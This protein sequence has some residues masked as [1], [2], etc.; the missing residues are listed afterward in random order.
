[1]PDNEFMFY[2]VKRTG[3]IAK[4]PNCAVLLEDEWDD[5]FQFS[6]MYSVFLFDEEGNQ[7]SLGSVKIGQVDMKQDQRR[8]D[9]PKSFTE[10]DERFFSLGQSEEYYEILGKLPPRLKR[11]IIDGLRD[12][13]ADLELWNRA[14]NKKVTDVSLTRSVSTRS[15]KGQFRRLLDG[16]A[17]L[18]PYNFTFTPP[19]R[20]NTANLV[21]RLEFHV[22][23]ESNPPTNV[24]V[25]IGRNGVGKTRMLHL[26]TKALVASKKSAAQSGKFI[27][28]DAFDESDSPFSGVVTVSFSAFDENELFPEQTN[29]N[30]SLRYYYIGL[31]R[32]S[33]EETSHGRP[34]SPKTL[35]KE[36]VASVALCL[37]GPRS[38]RWRRALEMLEADQIFKEAEVV[39][40]AKAPDKGFVNRK[41]EWLFKHLSSGHKIVLLTMTRLVEVVEEKTLVLIDEPEAHLH[42]PLLSAFVRSLSDLLINR[43]GVAIIATHSPVVLQEVPKTC[44]W[45]LRRSGPE[46]TAERPECETFGE[47]VG[48]LTREVFKLEVTQTGFHRLLTEAA[49]KG[50]SFDALSGQFKDELGAEA[51]AILRALIATR[52]DGGRE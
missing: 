26:M 48:V 40:L 23:P 28:K 8:P 20:P 42:P 15:I 16:G 39:R 52:Q 25:L 13:V 5:W 31:R 4:G 27:W 21:K 38:L 36:F 29:S 46:A 43:N 1:M 49:K 50:G 2:V 7:Q 12:V 3:S 44:V 11:K 33:G 24:H 47:N 51:R 35:A 19:E 22:E 41:S 18:T 45:M 9:L 10:L 37:Q 32:N 14:K 30:A 34:K 6:T 17:R